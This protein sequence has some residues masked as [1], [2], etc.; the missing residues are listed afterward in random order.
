VRFPTRVLRGAGVPPVERDP[1]ATAAFPADDYDLSPATWADIDPA[2][3]DP[4][5]AWSAAKAFEHKR[6]HAPPG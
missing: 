2:L 4:G 1:F 3:T 6:R 5:I